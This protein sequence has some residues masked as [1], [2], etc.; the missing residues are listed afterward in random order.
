MFSEDEPID[1]DKLHMGMPSPTEEMLQSPEFEAV[2]GC[3]KSW[4]V[5]VPDAYNGY[6]G[7]TG[8]HVCLILDALAKV[9]SP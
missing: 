1:Q 2:W 3:I 8:S 5:N 9:K 6:M 7:A 4:D